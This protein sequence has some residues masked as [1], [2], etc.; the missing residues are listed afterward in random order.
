MATYGW[1]PF[2]LVTVV[3][4]G[5]WF[6]LHPLLRDCLREWNLCPCQL[7]PNGFKTIMGVV[8]LN[9]ILGIS[10]SVL[11]IKDIYDRCTSADGNSY[12]LRLRTGRGGFVTSLEDSYRYAGDDR[13][14]VKGEWEF[15]ESEVSTSVRIPRKM[16]TPP[17]KGRNLFGFQFSFLFFIP[18]GLTSPFCYAD[19]RQKR[20]LARRKGN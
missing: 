11:D 7:L 9:R 4:A 12:Y 1:M 8:Q 2:W 16:G 17:S 3:E 6:P 19:F 10:L 13:V 15:G 14:F 18:A 20:Q 5:V